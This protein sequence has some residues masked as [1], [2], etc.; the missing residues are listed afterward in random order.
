MIRAMRLGS[1]LIFALAWLLGCL[2][3][4]AEVSRDLPIYTV[5]VPRLQGLNL[6]LPLAMSQINADQIQTASTQ[7]A[8]DESLQTVPGVF[9]LNPYNFAQDSRIAIRG[10]GARANFGIRGIRLIV[11]GIPATTPDGQGSVDGLD[12]GSA[13]SVEVLRGPASA[14]YG[15]SSG[16]VILVETEDGPATPFIETRWTF[17]E[18]GLRQTQFKTG[19]QSGALNY[20]IS[21]TDLEFDGY[22]AHNETEN[23]RVNAKF[24]YEFNTDS[25]LTAIVSVI[26]FPLQNDPG[27]L[28]LE[29]VRA[30]RAQA[31]QRNVDF[32]SGESVQQQQLG[33]IYRQTL[34]DLH[35]VELNSYYTHRDFANKLPFEGGGQV[36]FERDFFGAGALYRF[37]GDALNV[38]AGLDY[39]F[40]DDAR[41]NYDNLNGVRGPLSLRQK[42][43][44]R[45]VGLFVSGR[46]AFHDRLAASASL[47]QDWLEF[48]VNDSFSVD[49]DDSGSRRF[50][51]TSPMLGLSWELTPG[52][53]LFA[54]AATSFETPTTTE[55]AN[56]FGGG[57]NPALESQT[58]QSFEVGLKGDRLINERRLRYELTA[59]QI[60]I[61][62]A[63]VPF[64]LASAPGR[65]FYQ[66]AGESHR[67][68]IEAAVQFELFN[69]L[70]FDLSYTWSDFQ[71]KDF[72]VPG[73]DF[74]GNRL[75]GI[76]EHFGNVRID[77]RYESGFFV[78]WNTRYTGKLYADDA[79]SETVESYT[80]SDLRVGIERILGGW[81]V[82]P[83]IGINNLFDEAYNSNV[84]IN[85]FGARYYEPA[86]ERN[87]YTGIRIRYAFQ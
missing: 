19:G 81:T 5:S 65:E 10:F 14:L 87:I 40:Q 71:Y 82:E 44:I 73:G 21:A 62:D 56:P 79:N 28:T 12:L 22:R 54:N 39:D 60:Q 31:R 43:Q 29:E 58:A 11:D 45:S 27:G 34:D 63:L 76:P 37:T 30:D 33:F 35:T 75:P 32:D 51:E 7:L 8:L 16:G 69:N 83:F 86:P 61:E 26:D 1:H 68:G 38:V 53:A 66:N 80:V 48:E 64:E 41:E 6:E 52:W 57:F 3:S 9:V 17:G 46:W 15:A 77:Y 72:E 2:L 42:E 4:A 49:G 78:R 36:G 70:Q 50:D 24:R 25:S 59:F 74:R 13:Q 85:A 18:D 55:L 47:R 20:L 67:T 23:Q 84:R